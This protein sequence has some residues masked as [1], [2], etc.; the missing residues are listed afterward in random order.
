MAR[1]IIMQPN[2]KYCIYNSNVDNIT[3]YNMGEQDII[4]EWSEESR[5][6][7]EKS[8]KSIVSKLKE[9]KRPYYQ[10]TKTYE[11]MLNSIMDIHGDEEA[12][13]VRKIIEE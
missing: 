4:E 7:I 2:G 1:Q 13:D 5:K 6:E 11:E 3:H 8:V 9:G 10:F 12:E